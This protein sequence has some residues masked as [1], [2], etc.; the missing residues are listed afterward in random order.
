MIPFHNPLISWKDVI[1]SFTCKNA[2]EKLKSEISK[3]FGV[4]E[5]N[6]IL[7]GSGRHAL[8][9]A[10]QILNI[11]KSD[12]VIIPSFICPSVGEAVLAV[13]ATPVFVD[14]DEGSFNISP[15]ITEEAISEKTKAIV[16][17]HIGGIPVKIDEFVKISKKYDIPLI[18]DCAQ[19]FGAKYN[20]ILTG[21]FGDFGFF[22]FGIS[23][24]INGV[25][26]GALYTKNFD[27]KI[28][29]SFNK[30]QLKLIMKEYFTA[31]SAPIVF[32][33]TVYGYLR[34]YLQSYSVGKYENSPFE[35]YER[36]ITNI[37]ACIAFSKIK[38]YEVIKKERNKNAK[39]YY[40]Y[41]EGVFDFVQIPEKAE[42]AYLY[43]PVL[44]KNYGEVKR[45]KEE[46]FKKGIEVKDKS[47]MRYFALWEHP[48]FRGYKHYGENVVDIEN[49]YLLFPLTYPK[50]EVIKIC[51]QSTRLMDGGK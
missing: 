38:K 34:K 21:L 10:L 35:L 2:K 43:L 37:E 13:G 12:E 49:R 25:A 7:T 16:V 50:K 42:P 5:D 8:K 23:K 41:F 6:I 30:P 32:N 15:D 26:G 29:L 1:H 33:N 3:Y 24:N 48:R 27:E 18:E 40:E 47:D 20:G 14:V 45:I 39:L 51:E 46:L 4:N 9:L 11:K 19:S 17:A 22:S 44:V 28:D 36:E 31:L